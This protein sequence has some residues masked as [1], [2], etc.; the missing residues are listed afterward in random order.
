MTNANVFW[1][2][3]VTSVGLLHVSTIVYFLYI[4]ESIQSLK[5]NL[6]KYNIYECTSFEQ[7]SCCICD[8]LLTLMI[9]LSTQILFPKTPV[10]NF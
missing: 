9:V 7:T 6:Y 3:S 2:L 8:S 1:Y 5:Y 4:K 10:L